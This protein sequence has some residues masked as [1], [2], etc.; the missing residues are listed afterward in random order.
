MV[1]DAYLPS[2]THWGPFVAREHDGVLDVLPHPLDPDPST[3]LGNIASATHHEARVSE[4]VVRRSWLEDGPGPRS[5]NR[6]DEFVA[7]G[8]DR[9]IELV[10]NELDR[11]R[12]LHGNEA[13][14]GGSYGWASA[15]RFHPR[16]E[17]GAPVPEPDRRVC[18][19][20]ALVQQRCIHGDPA[21]HRPGR[22]SSCCGGA[23]RGSR[24]PRT[25]S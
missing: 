15:G 5:R 4:P 24:S 6:D 23:R 12:T 7:V 3:L 8:W 19:I 22:V 17:P 14:Y 10:A 18:P 20:G 9:A 13:I 1:T 11:V 21:L 2:S 25:A 16:S